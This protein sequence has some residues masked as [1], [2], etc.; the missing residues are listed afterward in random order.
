MFH[1]VLIWDT[2]Y[3][4]AVRNTKCRKEELL[5]RQMYVQVIITKCLTIFGLYCTT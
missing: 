1:T 4:I 2:H 5:E 3:T